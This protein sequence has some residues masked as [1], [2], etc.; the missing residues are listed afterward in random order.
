MGKLLEFK[1]KAQREAKEEETPSTELTPVE[2]SATEIANMINTMFSDKEKERI[3]K[4][5]MGDSE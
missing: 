1:T 2:A 3:R 4:E 5:L